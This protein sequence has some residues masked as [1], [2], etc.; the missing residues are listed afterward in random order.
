MACVE[1]GNERTEDL[2][3]TC[4]FLVLFYMMGYHLITT[5][6]KLGTVSHCK[7]QSTCL[8]TSAC[9]LVREQPSGV[10][11]LLLCTPHSELRPGFLNRAR[12]L[13]HF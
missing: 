1:D 3:V 6:I 13:N 5:L 2:H 7:V 9:V 10:R 4:M 11:P 12:M 8:N